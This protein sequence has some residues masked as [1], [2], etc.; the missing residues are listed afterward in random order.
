MI[1]KVSVIIPTYNREKTILRALNSVL[2]Q[3]YSNIEVLVIDDGSTDATAELVKGIKDER[4]NYIVLEKNGGPSNARNAGVQM[5]EGEWIAF[6]DSDDCWHKDKLEKQIAYA[7]EHPEYTMIYCMYN[8]ILENGEQLI[9]PP[10]PW[11]NPMDGNMVRTLLQRNMIG[12]PTILAK[13]EA[14]L[15]TGGFDTSYKALEDWDFA[16]RFALENEIGFVTEALMDCYI[17]NSGVSSNTGAYYEARCKMLGQYKNA[18]MQE[19]VLET[20]MQ[21][22]LMRAQGS[23]VADSVKKMMMMYLCGQ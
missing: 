6:Q 10:K 11:M 7:K 4:V 22:I 17:S 9:I 2:N 20:V 18:M 21:D 13:K 8:A 12:A 14:F 23:G 3:T 16:I 19:G 1:D 5:A 15:E